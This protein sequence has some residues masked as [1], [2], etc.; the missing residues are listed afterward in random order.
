MALFSRENWTKFEP[1]AEGFRENR[2]LLE[3]I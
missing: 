1:V 2:E 3:T